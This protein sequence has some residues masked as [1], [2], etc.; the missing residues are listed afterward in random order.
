MSK[1]DKK[2]LFSQ[3]K[4]QNEDLTAQLNVKG[5][6]LTDCYNDLKAKIDRVK[7]LEID[8]KST[9]EHVELLQKSRE[10]VRSAL[11]FANEHI[12]TLK[13]S[14]EEIRSAGAANL[15]KL[16]ILE[17]MLGE[18]AF[19]LNEGRKQ[20]LIEKEKNIKN[21]KKLTEE[22]ESLEEEIKLLRVETITV[23]DEKLKKVRL[24][25]FDGYK[26]HTPL[27]K[28]LF[29]LLQAVSSLKNDSTMLNQ[30][31]S[32]MEISDLALKATKT[33]NDQL[34][35]EVEQLNQ[36]DMSKKL[37]IEK[38]REE[39]IS[40]KQ[41]IET[42]EQENA[43]LKL[44]L[45]SAKAEAEK[46]RDD[47]KEDEE[48]GALM[49]SSPPLVEIPSAELL[50]EMGR[51]ENL[52]LE[53]E[54][55]I[56]KLRSEVL[57][58]IN[59][60]LFKEISN[61]QTVIYL[62]KL[63]TYMIN[64]LGK[65]DEIRVK[66]QTEFEQLFRNADLELKSFQ[67]ECNLSARK[68]EKKLKERVKVDINQFSTKLLAGLI[69]DALKEEIASH[70]EHMNNALLAE[71][72][73]FKRELEHVKFVYKR[74]LENLKEEMSNSYGKTLIDLTK[75]INRAN[76]SIRKTNQIIQTPTEKQI[77]KEVSQLEVFANRFLESEN[78]QKDRIKFNEKF[79]IT[80]ED[81][82]GGTNL[83]SKI[84]YF[85]CSQYYRSTKVK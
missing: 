18:D 80:Y 47:K 45:L 54:N 48:D 10:D 70:T 41:Q 15:K 38:L 60:D 69:K 28:E 35:M 49:V 52:V 56:K 42:L 65:L 62:T 82:M 46:K 19:E 11:K 84:K 44:S 5:K 83:Y 4:K 63:R 77:L 51:T 55:T 36:Q 68:L 85:N 12:E 27:E 53:C 31:V 14:K 71:R 13:K 50:S 37:E 59:S 64:E 78:I 67:A 61:K 22:I 43:S 9:I 26:P 66:Q 3:V 23:Y 58:R 24:E 25:M 72:E 75:I 6:L 1:D 57:A 8:L 32:A 76:S 30:Y 17:G 39:N 40:Q 7:Q 79:Q 73:D 20:N 34:K 74:E 29:N 2:L 81:W 21:V 16:N 33:E